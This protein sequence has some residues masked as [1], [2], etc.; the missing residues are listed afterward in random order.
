MV[1]DSTDL[2]L[3]RNPIKLPASFIEIDKPI[4]KFTRKNR[5][6]SI[7]KT[8]LKKKYQGEELT[9]P[10]FMI[11]TDY[12]QYLNSV[13]YWQKERDTESTKQNKSPETDPH[14]HG[15]MIF[16]KDTNAI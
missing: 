8:I 13:W 11:Y 4:A 9:L 5:G 6:L 16:N 15:H 12:L 7:V 1:L 2:Q 3:Q 14:T 10:D